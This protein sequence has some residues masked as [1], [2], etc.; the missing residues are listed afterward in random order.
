MGGGAQPKLNAEQLKLVK[1]LVD[2]DNDATLDELR[3]RLAAE[4]S[5]LISRSS[6]GRIVQ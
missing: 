5:I 6:M 2:A 3:D 4:T 1:A